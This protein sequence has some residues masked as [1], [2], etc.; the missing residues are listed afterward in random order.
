MAA[1]KAG[2][3]ELFSRADGAQLDEFG[4]PIIGSKRSRKAPPFNIRHLLKVKQAFKT[5]DADGDGF[6]KK[7][8]FYAVKTSLRKSVP[9]LKFNHIWRTLDK[10]GTWNGAPT[11]VPGQVTWMEFLYGL[12]EL[13]KKLRRYLDFATIARADSLLVN[14]IFNEE[15][16]TKALNKL[17]MLERFGVKMLRRLSQEQQQEKR[18]SRIAHTL[19]KHGHK[20]STLHTLDKSKSTQ[21]FETEEDSAQADE[22]DD[23]IADNEITT[24]GAVG[25]RIESSMNK[26]IFRVGMIGALASA[27]C[28]AADVLAEHTYASLVLNDGTVIPSIKGVIFVKSPIL[29]FAAV[30]EICWLYYDTLVECMALATFV[31]LVLWPLDDIRSSVAVNLTRAALEMGGSHDNVLHINALKEASTL[32]VALVAMIYKAKMGVSKFAVKLGVKRVMTRCGVRETSSL[33]WAGFAAVPVGFIWNAVVCRAIIR[34]ARVRALGARIALSLTDKMMEE[35]GDKRL[36]PLVRIQCLR[37]IGITIV[38][39]QDVHPNVEILLKRLYEY[40]QQLEKDPDRNRMNT[41]FNSTWSNLEKSQRKAAKMLGYFPPKGEEGLSNKALGHRRWPRHDNEKHGSMAK[42][43]WPP[44]QE[45]SAKH[46]TAAE[47][48]GLFEQYYPPG[49]A[50]DLSFQLKV[51]RN[52]HPCKGHA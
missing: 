3:I 14:R 24:T 42:H 50:C 9:I 15:A 40:F 5:A 13:P 36:R 34:E 52:A 31:G 27:I 17:N 4:V 41:A 29:A 44:W 32:K 25:K 48:L 12:A 2:H 43:H 6:I 11:H 51:I 10:Q 19:D 35:W 21:S 49:V 39:A 47:E 20:A 23:E 28:A 33:A 22:Y 37:I 18:V 46:K 26:C 30:L 45:M 8:E 1:I 7:K 16:H 38:K